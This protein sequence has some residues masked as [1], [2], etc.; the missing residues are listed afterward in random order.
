MHGVLVEP[1][2]GVALSGAEMSEVAPG[3]GRRGGTPGLCD[4]QLCDDQVVDR[5]TE[6]PGHLGGLVPGM[7][8]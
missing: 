5:W 6:A 4:G 8:V 3:S 1:C 7:E 2:L